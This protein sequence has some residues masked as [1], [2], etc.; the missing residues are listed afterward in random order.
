MIFVEA[1]KSR[2][3]RWCDQSFAHQ[4]RVEPGDWYG[5]V[6]VSPK[7]GIMGASDGKWYSFP[8]C[9]SCLLDGTEG[10][11]AYFSRDREGRKLVEGILQRKAERG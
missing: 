3:L 10:R 11:I 1:R 2:R 6:S 7:D 5:R 8:V 4:R 9:L